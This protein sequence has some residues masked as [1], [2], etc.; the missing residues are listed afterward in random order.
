MTRVRL[1]FS[2]LSTAARNENVRRVE[3]AWGAAIAAEWAHFVALGVF[4]Y[5]HGGAS[6]VGIAGLVRL[7]PAAVIAPF[8]ASLGDRFR[9]ERFLLAMLVA[10][11]AALAGSAAAAYAGSFTLVLVFAAF[12]G[13]SSTLV[14]PALQALLPSLAHTPEELIAANGASSTVEGA[15][16]RR[17]GPRRRARLAHER[18]RRLPRRRRSVLLAAAALLGRVRIEGRPEVGVAVESERVRRLV[19]AGFRALAALPEGAPALTGLAASQAFVRGCL[20]VLIVVLVFRELDGGAAEVGYLTAAMGAGGLI[21]AIGSMTLGARRLAVV[22]GIAL[23]FW[24]LPIALLAP[25]PYF[26][27]ALFLL[28][29]IG[30]A[31]TVE[32]V[33]VITLLQR[34]VPDE[35]LTRVLGVF[36]GLAMGGVAIGSIAAPALVEAVGAGPPSSPSG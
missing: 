19:V 18:Q 21:G 24:G 20:N 6:A 5:E 23:V 35:L 27:T 13:V 7:L 22:F 14:R 16:A 31:N 2:A 12:L 29:I 11:A 34:T 36:W 32:D 9:R 1:V 17:T 3:L 28:A 33:A 15:G 26:A 4:A 10:G 25:V 8:A 30:A